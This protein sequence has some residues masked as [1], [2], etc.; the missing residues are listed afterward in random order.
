MRVNPNATASR[1]VV[2]RVIGAMLMVAG[3]LIPT[4]GIAWLL[5]SH[6]LAERPVYGPKAFA[7]VLMAGL[8]FLFVGA[9]YLFVPDRYRGPTVPDD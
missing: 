3:V 8:L 7:G 2:Q 9:A 4:F 5:S 1:Y 6:F